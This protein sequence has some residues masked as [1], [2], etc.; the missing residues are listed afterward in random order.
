MLNSFLSNLR[1][2][3]HSFLA[4]SKFDESTKFLNAYNRSFKNHSFFEISYNCL[5]VLKSLINHILVNATY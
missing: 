1:N 3:N 5:N 4:R 2:V